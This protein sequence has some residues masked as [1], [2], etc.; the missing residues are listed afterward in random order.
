MKRKNSDDRLPEIRDEQIRSPRSSSGSE[1]RADSAPASTCH[2][3]RPLL[4]PRIDQETTSEER[5]A[6]DSHVAAC[7]ACARELDLHRRIA[8]ALSGHRSR[9][10]GRALDSG[11]ADRVRQA[12]RVASVRTRLTWAASLA[13]CAALAVTIGFLGRSLVESPPGS[14]SGPGVAGA[15]EAPSDELL[16][17]LDV[18]EALQAEGLEPSPELAQ[19]LLDVVDGD[20]GSRVDSGSRGDF[21][22]PNDPG[23][24]RLDESNDLPWEELSPE[25]L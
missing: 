2:A 6:V 22:N 21:G 1:D 14:H 5:I 20:F 16:G 8:A 17:S 3:I 23:N 10:P 18:L 12:A 4:V 7:A 24:S 9:G 15:A 25:N 19:V 11:L 13:A